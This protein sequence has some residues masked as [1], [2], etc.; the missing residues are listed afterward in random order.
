[1]LLW[2]AA[3]AALMRAAYPP[4]RLWDRECKQWFANNYINTK[5]MV[6]PTAAEYSD[7]ERNVKKLCIV[8]LMIIVAGSAFAK[9]K[10]ALVIGNSNYRHFQT[11][12]RPAAEAAAMKDTLKR[13]GFEVIFVADGTYEQMF[14]ALY[15]FERKLQERKGIALFHYGGHGV[16]VGGENYL[17]PVDKDVPDE[18]RVRSRAVNANEIV[19]LLAAAGSTTNILI[20]DACRDNPLPAVSRSTNSRGLAKINAPV[21]TVIV[22]SAE[23]GQTAEDGIFTPTLLEYIE[24]PGMRFTDVLQQTRRAVWK[25]TG[26]QQKPGSYDMLFDPIYLAGNVQDDAAAGS[27]TGGPAGTSAAAALDT[28]E[29]PPGFAFVEAG[30]FLMGSQEGISG[31]DNDEKLHT[32]VLSSNFYIAKH[33]V[34]QTEYRS[35]MGNNPAADSG[36]E[37]YTYPVWN[38]SWYDAINYCN[39]RSLRENLT[40]CYSGSGNNIQCNFSANGYRLPTE[41]EWEY[42]AHGGSNRFR[43][44]GSNYIEGAA[45]YEENSRGRPHP[46]RQKLANELGIFDLGGNVSEWCWDWKGGYPDGNVTDPAGPSSGAFRII[47]GGNWAAYEKNCRTADRAISNPNNRND[48]IGFRVVRTAP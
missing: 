20:L 39:A 19:A 12:S 1:M 4:F 11:L 10:T 3:Y 5:M 15:R 28:P 35:V 37:E 14:D 26:G 36:F 43:F 34:T 9:N 8:L 47:R 44:P 27:L 48:Q 46:I 22:Y 41:A 31:R 6:K 38:V 21:N 40:P 33:E 29:A 23:S 7:K 18:R 42:A 13:L 16:Q 30:E 25:K 2:V 24:T 32:V 45:W 17:L